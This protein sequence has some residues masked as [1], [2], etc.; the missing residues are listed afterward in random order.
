L[1]TPIVFLGG[2]GEI[3][4]KKE[5]GLLRGEIVE[6]HTTPLCVVPLIEPVDHV[7][8]VGG[9]QPGSLLRS[10]VDLRASL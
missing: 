3:P 6:T 10:L 8:E 9:G 5:S 1:V 2:G 4:L 7:E